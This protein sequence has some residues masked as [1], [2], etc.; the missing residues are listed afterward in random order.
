MFKYLATAFTG[1]G[2][3]GGTGVYL[4]PETLNYMGIQAT[5]RGQDL[6][7]TVKSEG[8]NETKQ[9]TC[10]GKFGQYASLL[11]KADRQDWGLKAVLSCIYTDLRQDL[12]KYPLKETFENESLTCT[13]EGEMLVLKC[14]YKDKK[15]VLKTESSKSNEI[16]INL[17]KK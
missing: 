7:Y 8:D 9:L 6:T 15:I 11:L 10:K 3:A 13:K 16:V 5:D 14:T 12:T 1:L 4:Y 17:E 2:V